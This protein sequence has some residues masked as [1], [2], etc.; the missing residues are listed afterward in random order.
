M[1]RNSCFFPF[2]DN[3]IG[4][5]LNWV[6]STFTLLNSVCVGAE[7]IWN[8]HS[9][10][11]GNSRFLLN[12]SLCLTEHAFLFIYMACSPSSRNVTLNLLLLHFRK[13]TVSHRQ[14]L[15]NVKLIR[16]QEKDIFICTHHMPKISVYLI[17]WFF[18][19]KLSATSCCLLSI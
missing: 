18:R 11:A 13:C 14:S 5:L 4:V 6:F 9:L 1:K 12:L 16:L 8:L 3:N 15:L 17:G 10:K 2:S 7:S 19:L